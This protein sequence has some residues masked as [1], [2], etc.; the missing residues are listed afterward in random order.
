MKFLPK[1]VPETLYLNKKDD[2]CHGKWCTIFGQ[3]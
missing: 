2:T 1:F 3:F